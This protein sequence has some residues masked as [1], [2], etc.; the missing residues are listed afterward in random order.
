MSRIILEPI[1]GAGF[2]FKSTYKTQDL[3]FAEL[4]KAIGPNREVT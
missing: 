3:G 2:P 4:M 1:V